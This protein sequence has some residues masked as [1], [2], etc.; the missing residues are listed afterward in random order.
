M[1]IVPHLDSEPQIESPD[2]ELRGR[3]FPLSWKEPQSRPKNNIRQLVPA[4]QTDLSDLIADKIRSR[5]AWKEIGENTAATRPLVEAYVA[6]LLQLERFRG[7]VDDL[8][9]A[10][11]QANLEFRQQLGDTYESARDEVIQT[12]LDEMLKQAASNWLPARNVIDARL[13]SRPVAEVR[14]RLEQALDNA[15]RE[16]CSQFFELLARCVDRELMGLVEWL[17]N[18]CCS[19][20]FF[21]RVVIQENEGSSRQVRET[22]FQ[23]VTERD[24]ATGRQIIG[25]R[26]I[27]ETRGQGRHYHRCARHQHDVMN[28]IHTTIGNSKVAMPPPV[29]RLCE[30]VPDWLAPF[31]QVIDGTIFRER[32]VERDMGVASWKDV[33]SHDEPIIGCEPGII[34]GHFVLTGWGPR[35]VKAEML[36]RDSV[37][38]EAA[39]NARINLAK[40]RFPALIAIAITLA[41]I[42]VALATQSLSGESGGLTSPLV[43]IGAVACAWQAALDYATARRNSF[44]TAWA[45]LIVASIGCQFLLVVWGI[46]RLY[47]PMPWQVPIVLA[48]GAVAFHSIS[49]R[50]N[51]HKRS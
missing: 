18:N 25:K 47:Q 39:A 44:A 29:V 17:P 16:F 22:Q 7:D 40:L 13:V 27:E 35:E 3:R 30:S 24:R 10:S 33:Q 14:Q 1:M 46:T 45:N 36:R 28:A 9:R 43:A 12:S 11:C 42:A 6:S 4:P 34:I 48:A 8:V 2:V 32:I 38:V 21:K 26:T 49:Q 20:H 19:Y 23:R 41:A 5:L 31:V 37:K 50:F 51:N 15:V